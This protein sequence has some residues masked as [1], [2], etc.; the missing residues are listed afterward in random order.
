MSDIPEYRT[1][2][3]PDVDP[4]IGMLVDTSDLSRPTPE[5]GEQPEEAVQIPSELIYPEDEQW[6]D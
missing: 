4:T 2:E 6:Q 3:L 5:D 1:G